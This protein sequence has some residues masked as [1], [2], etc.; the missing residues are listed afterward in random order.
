ME[1]CKMLKFDS[2]FYII[3]HGSISPGQQ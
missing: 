2:K 3:G 1:P